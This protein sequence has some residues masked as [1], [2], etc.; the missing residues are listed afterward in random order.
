MAVTLLVVAAAVYVGWR[1]WTH[2]QQ[3]PWTRDGRVRA[4]V[5]QVA[6]DVGGLV[7]EAPAQ[8]NQRV[9]RGDLLFVIDPQRYQLA[10]RQ[11]EAALAN[12]RAALAQ[13]ERE[14]RRNRIL[15]DLVAAET[16]EQ[17]QTRLDEARAAVAQAE[18]ALDTARLNLRRTRVVAPADGVL[19]F[20]EV[21]A[22]AYLSPGRAAL[23]LVDEGS[24]HVD[25]YFEETKLRR[26]HIGDR[27]QVRIMGEPQ[28]LY[29]VVQSISPAVTDRDR[30]EASNLVPNVNPTFSWV[31][32]A[33]R[34][35]V[36]IMLDRPPADVRL[37]AG[38]TATVTIL[39]AA[40]PGPQPPPRPGR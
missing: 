4:D 7:T 21:K 5:V 19:S 18:T 26:I 29:G 17:S 32:L 30:T 24:L 25:G 23:A 34:I 1:L 27:A 35:P 10:V 9:R 20:V 28:L 15:G 3:D 2:Y 22:G 39:P 8:D 13:A 14:T 6:P 38:R 31:R 12:Q 36:R 33:Q 11:A 40:P 37:I 16:T